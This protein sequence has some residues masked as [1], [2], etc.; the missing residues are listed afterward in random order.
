MSSEVLREVLQILPWLRRLFHSSTQAHRLVC[1]IDLPGVQPHQALPAARSGRLLPPPPRFPPHWRIPGQ[2]VEAGAGEADD[3]RCSPPLACFCFALAFWVA[4]F[5]SLPSAAPPLPP[6][7]LLGEAFPRALASLGAGVALSVPFS[8]LPPAVECPNC[9]PLL[10]AD[11]PDSALL[12]SIKKGLAAI[13]AARSRLPRLRLDLCLAA[14]HLCWGAIRLA[15]PFRPWPQAGEVCPPP[16][17][18]TSLAWPLST[19]GGMR[20]VS[21]LS[22]RCESQLTWL[23]T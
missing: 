20:L 6:L 23:T 18:K 10:E 5:F 14:G 1:H 16:C 19:L 8:G 4:C 11:P 21:L 15:H 17:G 7:P 12:S 13:L 9:F 3:P 2:L 22:R